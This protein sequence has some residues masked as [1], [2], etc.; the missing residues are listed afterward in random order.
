MLFKEVI[1]TIKDILSRF[2]GVNYVSYN[3]DDLNNAQHNRKTIQCYIDDV[4][5]SEFN[6]TTNITK[7]SM[8]IFILGFPKDKN[9]KDGILEVQ[10]ICYNIAANFLAIL[11][12]NEETQNIIRLY[13]Y[14]ILTLSHY[15]AQDNAGVKLSIILE[16]PS[17]VNLC[18]DWLNDEPYEEDGDI[19]IDI[20]TKDQNEL[21]LKKIKLPRNPVC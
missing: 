16:I 20:D 8:D 7:L 14:S 4:S 5:L 9:D 11:N 3:A 17:A 12:F 13:D 6:L 1:D 2:K 15:T 21:E 18:E 19:E 10:D